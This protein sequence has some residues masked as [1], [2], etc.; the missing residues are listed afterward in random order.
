MEPCRCHMN[1]C[2]RLFSS[3]LLLFKRLSSS[4]PSCPLHTR[5]CFYLICCLKSY[6]ADVVPGP[7]GAR[8]RAGQQR[9][10][11]FFQINERAKTNVI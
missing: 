4:H 11:V 3:A 10:K 8:E 5:A 1:E 7:E 2:R 6:F 9:E